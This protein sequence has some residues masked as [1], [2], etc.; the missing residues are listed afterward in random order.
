MNTRTPRIAVLLLLAASLASCVPSPHIAHSR[1]AVSGTLVENGVPIPGAALY[2]GKFA[3]DSQP[4]TEVGEAVPVTRE[5]GFSWPAVHELHLMDSL[6]NPVDVRGALT[7]LC[8][9][10]PAKGVLVAATLHM[11]QKNPLSLRLH[12]DVAHPLSS[13]G[14]G[15]N[16]ASAMPGQTQYCK[17]TATGVP[18]GSR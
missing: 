4:C 7:V 6:I 2:L 18:G 5:G 11:R 10:H 14:A 9:R 15:P 16:M 8:I 17:A 13:T 1:P 12:C 3:G